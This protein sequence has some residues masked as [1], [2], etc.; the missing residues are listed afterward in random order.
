MLFK[1]IGYL[2]YIILFFKVCNLHEQDAPPE[3]W[4]SAFFASLPVMHLI[5]VVM[6]TTAKTKGHEIYKRTMI[7][8]LLFAMAGDIAMIWP[9][10]NFILGMM[11]FAGTHL[12]YMRSFGFKPRG[13]PASLVS[14]FMLGSLAF[15]YLQP[16]IKSMQMQALILM[17]QVVLFG[18]FWRAWIQMQANPSIG[19][20]C[21]MIG[22]IVLVISDLIVASNRFIGKVDNGPMYMLSTYYIGQLFITASAAYYRPHPYRA[23]DEKIYSYKERL[24]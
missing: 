16:G 9:E 22:A 15:M 8:A 17:Y 4:K 11:F 13:P 10:K 1:I 18:M 24:N 12:F 2:L 7:I 6:S 5:F 14:C 20:A 21:G 3:T 19:S 23:T